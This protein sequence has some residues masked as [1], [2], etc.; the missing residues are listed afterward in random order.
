[1]EFAKEHAI[2]FVPIEKRS[3]ANF[4]LF[5]RDDIPSLHNEAYR[6]GALFI[7][8]GV[9]YTNDD[10]IAGYNGHTDCAGIG[11]L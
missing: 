6:R 3:C 8:S 2:D 11:K 7:I 1:M 9:I 10:E 5:S 4:K